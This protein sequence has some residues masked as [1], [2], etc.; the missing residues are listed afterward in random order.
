MNKLGF[1]FRTQNRDARLGSM[2]AKSLLYNIWQVQRYLLH[3]EG[4]EEG[5]LTLDEFLGKTYIHR[6]PQY[7]TQLI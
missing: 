5:P 2:G 6:Y 1:S 3:E 4:H 7:I